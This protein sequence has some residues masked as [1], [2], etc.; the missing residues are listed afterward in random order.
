MKG[1]RL[2]RVREVKGVLSKLGGA[3]DRFGDYLYVQHAN[4]CCAS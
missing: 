4:L 3:G 2:E 1:P